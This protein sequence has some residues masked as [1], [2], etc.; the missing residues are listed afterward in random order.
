MTVVQHGWWGELRHGGVLVAPQL[1]DELLPELPSLDEHAY[2]RLRAAWL[3]LD[4]A[5]H[6]GGEVD[7]ARRAFAA[8]VLEGFLGLAGWQKASAVGGE[9]KAIAVS[10]EHL[11]PNWVLPTSDGDGA[12]LAVFFDF[13]ETV[14][15]GRGVQIGRAHV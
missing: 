1:L 9:F 10:G 6:G 7:E 5:L 13:S 11:R 8:E 12:L 14:G 2:D 3:K 4:A 15:R